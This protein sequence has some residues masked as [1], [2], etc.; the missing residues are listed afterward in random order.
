M[1]DTRRR[2]VM[3]FVGETGAGKTTLLLETLKQYSGGMVTILDPQN[4]RELVQNFAKIP[5]D[6]IQYQNNG[7]YRCVTRDWKNFTNECLK[8]YNPESNKKGI[9]IYDDA[10]SYI[11]Q[12]EFK[13]LTDLMSGVRHKS[14]DMG[15]MFHN[16]WRIP[17]YILHSS[18]YITIF[19][20]GEPI[21]RQAAGR[22]PHSERIINAFLSVDA[23]PDPH[24]FEIVKIHG[25]HG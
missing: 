16:L 7:R 10:S 19:K 15:F 5:L 24:Y 17:P 20:T 23:N 6:K 4:E 11:T 18:T 21:D 25:V 3:T 22:F 2:N 13:P 14:L 8:N 12:D 1:T 9:I